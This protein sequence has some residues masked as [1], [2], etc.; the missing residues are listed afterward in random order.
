[1]IIFVAIVVT[2][3][4]AST[5]GLDFPMLAF[6]WGGAFALLTLRYIFKSEPAPMQVPAPPWSSFD[7]D[8]H[9]EAER[10]MGMNSRRRTEDILREA[11]EKMRQAA[12]EHAKRTAQKSHDETTVITTDS[13]K[14]VRNMLLRHHNMKGTDA[15]YQSSKMARD[16]TDMIQQINN[17]IKK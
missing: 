13:L 6:I 9:A 4:A 12:A 16:T 3:V 11:N 7:E 5:G 17:I 2:V 1:V 10:T 14:L 8:V 15:D